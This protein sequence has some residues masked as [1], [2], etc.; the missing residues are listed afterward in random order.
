MLIAY[1]MPKVSGLFLHSGGA[2]GQAWLSSDNG[3]ACF[4]EK[5]G[6]VSRLRW[7][8]DAVPALGHWVAV[9]VDMPLTKLRVIAFLGLKGVPEGAM[10][11]VYGQRDADAAPTYAFNNT[12][13]ANVVRLADGTLAAW[14]VLDA[15]AEPVKRL[16]WRFYNQQGAATW[17]TAVTTIDIGELVA[18]PAADIAHQS[19]WTVSLIDPTQAERSLASQL[20]TNPRQPYRQ[21]TANFT[22]DSIAAVRG[23]GLPNGM[24][25]E[26]LRA[27]L[28]MDRRCVVIPRWR[29]PA[30]ALDT[31]ELP[32][33]A[34]YGVGR[35]AEIQHQGGDFYS[36]SIT[37]MEVPALY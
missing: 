24:D 20:A 27:A 6:R 4:D 34:I 1:S 10:V 29:T 5:P 23:S 8:N 33:T 36:S 11:R 3:A 7:R 25:W 35:I 37:A 17:A 18:M 14:M 22:P 19:D 30:G 31:V 9:R 13:Q 2:A 32:R 15:A 16:E 12:N 28:T 26:R 21:I